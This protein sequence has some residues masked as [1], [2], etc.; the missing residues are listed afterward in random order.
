MPRAASP[1]P[2]GPANANRGP[3]SGASSRRQPDGRSAAACSG[4]S[5]KSRGR[6]GAGQ[7]GQRRGDRAQVVVEGGALGARGDEAPG[8]L[9]LGALGV[10]RGVGGDEQRVV[11]GVV[12]GEVRHVAA[13]TASASARF[14]QPAA[15]TMA[16]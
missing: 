6:T 9:E 8:R 3:A 7:G 14:R 10:A 1:V 4:V 12:V 5:R 15:R 13:L 16:A 2:S 11:V